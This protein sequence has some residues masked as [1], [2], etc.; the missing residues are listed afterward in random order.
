MSNPGKVPQRLRLYREQIR[1]M[2]KPKRKIWK[3]RMITDVVDQMG[4]HELLAFV[5]THWRKRTQFEE[6]IAFCEP[7]MLPFAVDRA[8]SRLQKET[9]AHSQ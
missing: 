4:H 3:E 9:K 6:L 1:H 7:D 5:N 2:P 8:K